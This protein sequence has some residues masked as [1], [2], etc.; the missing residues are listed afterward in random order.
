MANIPIRFENVFPDAKEWNEPKV[1][2]RV[3]RQAISVLQAALHGRKI[4]KDR[5]NAAQFAVG[6]LVAQ[7]AP[8]HIQVNFISWQ[9][10]A[11]STQKAGM[12]KEA[13]V[14]ETKEKVPLNPAASPPRRKSKARRSSE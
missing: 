9:D 5:L 7:D 6:K 12:L 10:I 3:R 2:D 13:K 11:K 4:D 8:K 1:L 14:I